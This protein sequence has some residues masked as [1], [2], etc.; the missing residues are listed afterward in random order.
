MCETLFENAN[1]VKDKLI[2]EGAGHTEAKYK[3]PDTYYNKMFDFI[4]T[5][6]KE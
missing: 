6:M 3:E 2:I 1:C 5:Y 4:N